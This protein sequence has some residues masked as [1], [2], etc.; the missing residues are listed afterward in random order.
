MDPWIQERLRQ[1]VPVS[2]IRSP[3]CL[4]VRPP[5]FSPGAA[6][7]KPWGYWH[8]L[9][10]CPGAIARERGCRRLGRR[11]GHLLRQERAYGASSLALRRLCFAV[12][13]HRRAQEDCARGQTAELRRVGQFT[14]RH[15]AASHMRHW[16]LNQT[17]PSVTFYPLGTRQT[18]VQVVAG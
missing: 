7:P 15:T 10:T 18:W 12:A 8:T 13:D 16:H 6:P 17:K 2:R 3:L 14:Q 9:I 1:P 4:P 5:P 11:K